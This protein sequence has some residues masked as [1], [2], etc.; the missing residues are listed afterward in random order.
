MNGKAES[1]ERLAIAVIVRQV[2]DLDRF[3]VQEGV[4]LDKRPNKSGAATDAV[5]CLTASDLTENDQHAVGRAAATWHN[6]TATPHP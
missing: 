4:V 3:E 5:R 2:F 6:S 1:V